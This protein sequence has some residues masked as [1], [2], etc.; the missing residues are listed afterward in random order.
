MLNVRE[1]HRHRAREST[2]DPEEPI[3]TARWVS[4]HKRSHLAGAPR[5]FQ[6]ETPGT[7]AGS[8]CRGILR[9]APHRNSRP[10]AEATCLPARV[11]VRF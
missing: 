6:K 9:P 7:A 3:V 1:F 10:D 2:R 8:N 11:W 5:L 4:L